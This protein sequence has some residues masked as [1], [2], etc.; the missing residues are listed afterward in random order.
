MEW[1]VEMSK[2]G[3]GSSWLTFF[4]GAL[5][6]AQYTRSEALW[7]IIDAGS[8]SRQMV[9]KRSIL[10]ADVEK[11]CAGAKSWRHPSLV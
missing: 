8:K 5:C 10:V 11:R 1:L 2:K 4:H 6:G 7:W 9:E 3:R